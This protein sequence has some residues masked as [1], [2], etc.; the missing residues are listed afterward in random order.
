MLLHQAMCQE[1][2]S[3]RSAVDQ[4]PQSPCSADLKCVVPI[5]W[6]QEVG[7]APLAV[8]ALKP[9]W[10]PHECASGC[11]QLCRAV[12]CRNSAPLWLQPLPLELREWDPGQ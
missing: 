10:G 12:G 7:E 3:V 8:V 1:S 11:S 4:M 5:Y 2:L 9:V 6:Q